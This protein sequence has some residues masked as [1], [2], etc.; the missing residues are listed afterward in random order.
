MLS[1]GEG[2]IIP[3][4]LC[5]SALHLRY[6]LTIRACARGS[7]TE[8]LIPQGGYDLDFVE[9]TERVGFEPT[10]RLRA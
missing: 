9:P 7:R 3:D 10:K 2:G 8:V 1:S 4:V 5:T 6:A